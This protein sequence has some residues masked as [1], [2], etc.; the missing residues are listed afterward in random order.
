MKRDFDIY[1]EEE[2]INILKK[3][4]EEKGITASELISAFAMNIRLESEK[5]SMSDT[6]ITDSLTGIFPDDIKEDEYKEYLEKKYGK[7]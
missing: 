4:A 1:L 6:P 2:D 7:Q 5:N 3:R